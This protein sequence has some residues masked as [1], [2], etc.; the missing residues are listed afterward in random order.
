M[1]RSQG[2]ID[3]EAEENRRRLLAAEVLFLAL[4]LRARGDERSF[5]DAILDGRS[6][7]R[8]AGLSRLAAEAASVG[9]TLGQ[10]SR[11]LADR[12]LDVGRASRAA[13]SLARRAIEQVDFTGTLRT[14]A[15]TENAQ[16]FNDGRA[17]TVR[18]VRVAELWRTWDA[19]LDR[20]ACP[21]CRAADGTVVGASESFPL[22]EPGSVH[23]NCRCTWTLV[24]AEEVKL[25]A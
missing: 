13:R 24:T 10:A 21:R 18:T 25:A 5:R 4:L 14:V 22:G 7:A 9:F 23:P 8:S 6:V 3:R 2:E 17:R 12:A 11:E 19:V 1:A 20:R 16:A 15:A